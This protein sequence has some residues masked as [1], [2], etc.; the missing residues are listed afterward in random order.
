MEKYEE[1]RCL[2]AKKTRAADQSSLSHYW[3]PPAVAIEGG[4]GKPWAC[5]ATTFEF[6]AEFF[7][8]ELLPQISRP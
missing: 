5:L 8:T 3:T 7:E 1:L 4:V 6:G 2:M